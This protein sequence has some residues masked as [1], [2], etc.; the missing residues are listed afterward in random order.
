[1][2]NTELYHNI[3]KEISEIVGTEA[4]EQIYERFKGQQV[5]FPIRL[6]S[7][8]LVQQR[9]IEEYD[10]SNIPELAKKYDYSEKSIRRMI[11]GNS[12]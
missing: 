8:E 10:G 4:T 6:Y 7:P 5:S 9:V 12:K 1:M 11:K 2:K 3:Y